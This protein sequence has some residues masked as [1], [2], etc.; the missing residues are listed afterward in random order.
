MMRLLGAFKILEEG[1][2][3][4][5]ATRYGSG[6]SMFLL[7]MKTAMEHP[8]WAQY[9]LRNDTVTNEVEEDG[10]KSCADWVTE[11]VPVVN[12]EE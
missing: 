8:E 3:I 12:H 10:F 5:P 6:G 7:G 2:L 9:I 1:M 4:F 11:M